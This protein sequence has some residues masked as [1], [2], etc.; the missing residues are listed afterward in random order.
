VRKVSALLCFSEKLL[1]TCKSC[2][3]NI[4]QTITRNNKYFIWKFIRKMYRIWI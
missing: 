3:I 4:F 2:L 1:Q